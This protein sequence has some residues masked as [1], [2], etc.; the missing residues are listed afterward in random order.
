MPWTDLKVC[1]SYF[2]SGQMQIYEL[3]VHVSKNKDKRPGKYQV[4][5]YSSVFKLR[6]PSSTF[7][8]S[9]IVPIFD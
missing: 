5:Q 3:S 7:L 9:S 4:M 1:P 8:L 6:K 2:L